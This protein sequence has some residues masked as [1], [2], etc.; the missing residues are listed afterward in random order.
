MPGKTRT[1]VVMPAY[2][3]AS[4]LERTYHDLPAGYVDEVIVVDDC[5]KDE[6][7]AVATRLGL[8]VFRHEVNKGYGGNQK[9]C[10]DRA[11]ERGADCVIMIHPWR[12]M[13]AST[14]LISIVV[15]R[16]RRG[17]VCGPAGS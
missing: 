7:V 10:Y 9:T 16:P 12:W 11:L 1:I 15:W 13:A 3:A 6:T 2:N 14:G 8:S 17:N 5:S 4:T